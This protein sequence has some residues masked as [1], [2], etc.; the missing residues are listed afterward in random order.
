[1]SNT[2]TSESRHMANKYEKKKNKKQ[3]SV[4]PSQSWQN[5]ISRIK[6]FYI[7]VTGNARQNAGLYLLLNSTVNI[8]QKRSS[9]THTKKAQLFKYYLT[10]ISRKQNH[11]FYIDFVEGWHG[12]KTSV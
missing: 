5:F 7:L 4:Q 1:M 6:T 9:L 11:L 10:D 12:W 3:T 2:I 8:C